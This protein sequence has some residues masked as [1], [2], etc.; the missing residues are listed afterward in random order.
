[1]WAT[2]CQLGFT[3]IF[4]AGSAHPQIVTFLFCCKTMLLSII[5]GNLTF[6]NNN[7]GTYKA[8]IIVIR[9]FP[10]KC[11]QNVI[12]FF[13]CLYFYQILGLLKKLFRDN[14]S[15]SSHK[16]LCFRPILHINSCFFTGRDRSH[17]RN[18]KFCSNSYY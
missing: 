15:A 18:A 17:L 10:F 9:H 11:S 5:A 3:I 12:L 2:P 8:I 4:S 14:F 13:R 1:V 6:A 7:E 16:R